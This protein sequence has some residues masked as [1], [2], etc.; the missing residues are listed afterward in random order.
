MTAGRHAARQ[1][2]R[3][4]ASP[5]PNYAEARGA[6]GRE[7]FVRKLRIGVK[8]LDE[9]GIRPLMIQ[10]ARMAPEVLITSPVSE[11]H[12]LARILIASIRTAQ[13]KGLQR[14]NDK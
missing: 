3:S 13:A 2:L 9:T 10:K 8:E 1:V 6:E 5:A 14:P 12:E 7:D 11:N 4:G